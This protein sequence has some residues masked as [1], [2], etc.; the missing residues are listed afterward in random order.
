MHGCRDEATS[1]TAIFGDRPCELG[2]EG[3]ICCGHFAESLLAGQPS[4]THSVK[5][6]RNKN[7]IPPLSAL[8][9]VLGLPVKSDRPQSRQIGGAKTHEAENFR[10]HLKKCLVARWLHSSILSL[11]FMRAERKKQRSR[12]FFRCLRAKPTRMPMGECR[13]NPEALGC[14]GTSFLRGEYLWHNR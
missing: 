13:E 6:H 10:P 1:G 5:E 9:F 12:A 2:V 7:R 4:G 14:Y 8:V 11:C 3:G